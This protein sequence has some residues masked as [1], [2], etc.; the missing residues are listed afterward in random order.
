MYVY[1]VSSFLASLWIE[2]SE[3]CIFDISANMI[4]NLKPSMNWFGSGMLCVLFTYSLRPSR[5]IMLCA[6]SIIIYGLNIAKKLSVLCGTENND[7]GTIPVAPAAIATLP[8]YTSVTPFLSMCPLAMCDTES[9]LC[10][11]T[12]KFV[13]YHIGIIFGAGPEPEVIII[14]GSISIPVCVGAIE[15]VTSDIEGLGN[16]T[17]VGSTSGYS[18]I[19][20]TLQNALPSGTFQ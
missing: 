13:V 2:E 15:V 3:S 14:P 4:P 18:P 6:I 10:I 11:V 17:D 9:V 1:F 20:F 8:L 19:K 16:T 7:I 5:S 12:K